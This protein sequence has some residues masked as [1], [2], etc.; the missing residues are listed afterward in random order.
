MK[1]LKTLGLASI[2]GLGLVALAGGGTAS[3]TTLSTDSGGFTK[4]SAG[5]EIYAT[6]NFGT[7]TLLETTSGEK[8]ATCTGSSIGGRTSATSEAF[9]AGWIELMTWESCSQTTDNV[10]LGGFEIHKTF[11][12]AGSF[13]GFFTEVTFGVFGVSCT[14][15]TLGSRT[16][17]TITGGEAPVININAVLEKRA[18]G[19]L[20]PSDARWTASYVVTSPHALHIVE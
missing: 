20:C 15:G 17:G 11:G 8:I 4:Y 16:F 7:S 5:T 18:G 3:A 14:Y 6:L 12:D 19:F 9:L 1:H 2:M 10:D 13:Y